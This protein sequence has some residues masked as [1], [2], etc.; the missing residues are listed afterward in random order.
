M[1]VGGQLKYIPTAPA[2]TVEASDLPAVRATLCCYE[3]WFGPYHPN[4]LRLM[5]TAGVTH[6]ELGE[7]GTARCLLE[8]AIRDLARSLGR[9]HE[10]R[11]RAIDG[12]RD[13][14]KRQRDWARAAEGQ[15]EL[16]ECRAL[17]LSAKIAQL[18]CDHPETVRARAEL[19]SILLEA[20][21]GRSREV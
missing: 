21:L 3:N 16:L 18:G 2:Q 17:V 10:A 11:L 19:G 14:C 6:A 15:K 8:R 9:E 4:T 7:L 20:P 12:L 1:T 5:V 13:V